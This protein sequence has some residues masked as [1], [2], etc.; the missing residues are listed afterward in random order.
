HRQSDERAQE[1]DVGK[2]GLGG[3]RASLLHEGE[4]LASGRRVAG[5]IA[6]PIDSPPAAGQHRQDAGSFPWHGLSSRA[7]AWVVKGISAVADR[8]LRTP[9]CDLF[10]IEYPIILAGMG[11]VSMAPLVAAVSNAGGSGVI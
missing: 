4:R 11:G 7:T 9:I 10:G 5:P 2:R 6:H 1:Q 8:A 3:A